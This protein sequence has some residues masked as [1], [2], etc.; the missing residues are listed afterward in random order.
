MD[1]SLIIF[2]AVIAFF[3]YRGYQKGLLA[4][5]SRILSLIAGYIAAIFFSSELSSMIESLGLLQ[6]IGALVAASLALF[7]GAAFAI[8]LVFRLINRLT[9]AKAENS[10]ISS[11]G[12]SVLGL[13][14]GVFVALIAVWSFTTARDIWAQAP[15]AAATNKSFVETIASRAT[16][17]A[18]EAALSLTAAKPEITRLGATLAGSP[19]KVAKHT[20]SLANSKALNNLLADP[21]NQEVLD[22]GNVEAVK[23]LPAFQQLVNNPDML[24]LTKLAGMQNDSVDNKNTLETALANQLTT[25]WLKMQSV[26]NNPRVQEILEDAEFQQKIQSGNPID[27]LSN[28]KLLELADMIFEDD[29]DA[30]DIGKAEQSSPA[31]EQKKEQYINGSTK[32]D[33]YIFQMKAPNSLSLLTHQAF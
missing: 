5:L 27:L 4:S 15:Q 13:L 7:T 31:T 10:P 22:S 21:V 25:N 29:F 19:A 1:W 28:A 16:S 2:I 33:G 23:A 18:A 11:L 9:G 24:A 6:G 20:Q 30:A 3:T 26:K 17:M 32:T 14:T 12:G 8:S